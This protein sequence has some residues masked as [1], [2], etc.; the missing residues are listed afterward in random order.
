MASKVSVCFFF[1]WLNCNWGWHVLHDLFLKELVGVLQFLGLLL[2]TFGLLVD[3]HF[4]SRLSCW[5]GMCASTI[6]SISSHPLWSKLSVSLSYFLNMKYAIMTWS[7]C[8]VDM[9]RQFHKWPARFVG[10]VLR[11]TK[12]TNLLLQTP[13]FGP[14]KN[15]IPW[16]EISMF[17]LTVRNSANS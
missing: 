12:S 3:K 14:W 15:V 17:F 13:Q 16:T 10:H 9:K 1:A 5:L 11:H 2:F 8:V 7:I 6:D 4:E